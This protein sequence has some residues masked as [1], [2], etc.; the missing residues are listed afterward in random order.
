MALIIGDEFVKAEPGDIVN[1]ILVIPPGIRVISGIYDYRYSD[2]DEIEKVKKKIIE[3]YLSDGVEFIEDY[4]F[5]K[6]VKLEKIRLPESLK[7]IGNG[8]F[9]ETNIKELDLPSNLE[10]LGKEAF[11]SCSRLTK[12]NIPV[13]IKNIYSETFAFDYSLSDIKIEKDSKLEYIGLAAF[14]F[15]GMLK[16]DLSLPKNILIENEAFYSCNSELMHKYPSNTDEKRVC[17]Q[18][19]WKMFNMKLLYGEVSVKDCEEKFKEFL[20]CYSRSQWIK[21]KANT[22]YSLFTSE[23]KIYLLYSMIDIYINK[24]YIRLTNG[25]LE[26][27]LNFLDRRISVSDI[28]KDYNRIGELISENR[29][30]GFW[31]D[32]QGEIIDKENPHLKNVEF[33]NITDER[34]GADYQNYGRVIWLSQNRYVIFPAKD[35]N[36][37]DKIIEMNGSGENNNPNILD[38]NSSITFARLLALLEIEHPRVFVCTLQNFK[39]IQKIKNM[40]TINSKRHISWIDAILGLYNRKI[41]TVHIDLSEQVK[42]FITLFNLGI[43]ITD[44]FNVL[45][46]LNEGYRLGIPRS[47]LNKDISE[48]Q[49][50]NPREGIDGVYQEILRIESEL[51]EIKPILSGHVKRLFSYEWVPKDN[52]LNCI[53]GLFCDCCAHMARSNTTYGSTISRA[54]VLNTDL[55]NMVIRNEKKGEIIGKTTIYVNKDVGYGVLNTF[56]VN[57]NYLKSDI[58]QKDIYDAFK[59]GIE[60][61]VDQ[62]NKENPENRLKQINVGMGFNSLREVVKKLLKKTDILEVPEEYK[63]QDALAGQYLIWKEGN[64]RI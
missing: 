40:K 49:G 25:E 54:V 37:I 14:A 8:V 18:N 52:P 44:I 33:A 35:T 30:F 28:E 48:F 19:T 31:S 32:L 6:L 29:K 17:D 61:F 38:K 3:I 21:Q 39:Y 4:A 50:N 58:I 12:V 16:S 36:I 53:L 24:D 46:T 27:F 47:L 7:Y 63:F 62:Y 26:E 5:F 15:C 56:H 42:D 45:E 10:Y 13:N 23:E 57:K 43:P 64:D 2:I 11:K 55:Q 9:S 59:R 34:K 60:A 22:I 41:K 1:G 20:G 51:R